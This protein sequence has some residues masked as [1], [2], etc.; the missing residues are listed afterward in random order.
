MK[1]LTR[2]EAERL[3]GTDPDHATKDLYDAIKRGDSPSWTLEMQI[4]TP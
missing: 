2:E 3:S 4:M 1:N